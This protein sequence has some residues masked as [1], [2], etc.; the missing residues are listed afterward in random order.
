MIGGRSIGVY[1]IGGLLIFTDEL[2][3]GLEYT[4]PSPNQT[5]EVNCN[6]LIIDNTLQNVI[7]QQVHILFPSNIEIGMEL[8]LE[9]STPIVIYNPITIEPQPIG[10]NPIGSREIGGY[11]TYTP[12]LSIN[13]F[14]I[15]HE[16][17]PVE[18]FIDDFVI[19]NVFESF[20]VTQ[21]QNID[22]P[23]LEIDNEFDSIVA[24]QAHNILRVNAMD[25]GLY[26]DSNIQSI[27]VQVS[28]P[29]DIQFEISFN[30]IFPQV[31]MGGYMYVTV[32][33]GEDIYNLS[34]E[35][36]ESE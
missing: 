4:S 20:L 34:F 26:F 36:I 28:F 30:K 12:P 2:E 31:T 10:V 6:P 1:E 8:E 15:E 22:I 14:T 7:P 16:L 35:G 32:T 25:F 5:Q 21:E 11:A 18:V 24:V 19:E 3:I 29:N 9:E 33:D 23:N 27:Q 13:D 17:Q